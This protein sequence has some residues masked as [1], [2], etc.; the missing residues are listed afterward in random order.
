MLIWEVNDKLMAVENYMTNILY[1]TIYTY[2][3]FGHMP[4]VKD[5]P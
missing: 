2:K 1:S 5:I 4:M 3:E